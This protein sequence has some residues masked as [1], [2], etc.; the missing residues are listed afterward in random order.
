[1]PSRWFLYHTVEDPFAYPV[2]PGTLK[3][4]LFVQNGQ[5]LSC[6]VIHSDRYDSPG[7]EIPLPMERI[8]SAGGYEIHE[9]V[10]QTATGKCRYL[11]HAENPAGEYLWYGERGLSEIR[12]HAG[13]FQYAYLHRSEAVK[14]PKWTSDT[15]V[16]QIYPSSFNGGTLKGVADK[17]P[18][19]QQLGITAIYMT[20]VFESPSEHKYNTSDYYKI[21][22]GFGSTADLKALVDL[23][24]SHGIKVLLDAVFNHAGDAFFAF[25][26]V[27][28]HGENSRYKDWF[29]I[30]SFPLVQSPSPNY[31]TFGKAEAHMPK[32]NM[33]NPEVADYMLEVSRH[34]VREAGIDGW[35]LDVANEVTPRFWTRFR[36][37]LKEEFPELLLIGEVMHASGPWLRGDQFDGGMNYVLR[38]A[39]LEFFAEQSAG[40]VRFLEQVLHQEAFC[41]DQANAAMFQLLGSHDTL[42][43]LTACREGGR[44]WNHENTAIQRMRLAVFFQMTY[45]GLPMIYYGDEV[46]MEGATDPHCRK[47]MVWQEQ[48]QN[49]ELHAWYTLLISLRR[50]YEVLRTGAFR[51]WFTDEA[52]NVLGYIRRSGQDSMGLV[53]NNSPNSYQLEPDSFRPDLH[54]LTDLLTGA[55][56][57]SAERLFVDV[58]PF[59]CLMLH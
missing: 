40:P 26:D 55:T 23:A 12:E 5:Q 17:I 19:L 46:G 25:K 1:M 13:S 2:G 53:I 29:V 44:G 34:W 41:N 4:R 35:R 32:L 56:V 8:G 51:L 45:I 39:V 3:L 21:D 31:E 27:L 43:F 14:L 16:Y 36:R 30:R 15:V 58:E 38:D 47:P 18:Y 37:E 42:R 52:R 49:M 24:H 57:R 59:G 22:P 9:A 7:S 50:Q 28:E 54:E 20:P 11:F 10:L 33:E 48:H 6:T